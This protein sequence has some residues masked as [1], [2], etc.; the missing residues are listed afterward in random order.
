MRSDDGGVT[1]KK[2]SVRLPKGSGSLF[3]SGIHPTDPD[4]VWFRVPG[5]GDAFGLLPARLW[6]STDG[7]ANFQPVA[8]TQGGMLGFAL[9]PDGDRVAFGGPLDGLF[10]APADASAAPTKVSEIQV[11]CL[12]WRSRGLYACGAEPTDPYALGY[13]AEPTQGFV[14]LWHRAN[15]CL[16]ACKAPSPLA[17]TC[18]EPWQ[19]LAPLIDAGTALCDGSESMPDAGI[20]AG[21]ADAGTGFDA[22]AGTVKAMMPA[23]SA[24]KGGCAVSSPAQVDPSW[25]LLP[26]W[27]VAGWTRRRVRG[28][29]T[30]ASA[31]R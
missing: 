30:S 7:A 14:P 18:R 25:W 11:H 22:G 27:M 15:T 8:N 23:T 4:R 20:D 12:R 2:S 13:A 1:W 28:A 24:S 5:R 21:P 19:A 17:M 26:M 31:S 3:V 16:G 29:F 6:L 9:S 10:V